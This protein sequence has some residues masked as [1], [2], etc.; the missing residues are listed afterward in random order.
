MGEFDLAEAD[1][2][3]ATELGP[4]RRGALRHAGQPRRDADP[5]GADT[6]PRP[7]TSGPRSRSKPDQFQAY[8]NLAQAYQ[9][10]ERF[11][12][13]LER[14]TGRSPG[15][16]GRRSCT[17]RAPRSTG[18]GRTTPKALDDLGRAIALSPPDDPA[19]AG[20]H[21]ER[22]LIFQQA[23]RHDEALAECD[24]ALALQPD[25]PDVH[26]VRGAVLVRLKRFDEAIRS[27]DVC[28]ARGTPSASLYE[29]R[30]LALA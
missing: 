20:D 23:G 25:R 29:A 18:S 27:F 10:L 24:R 19:L 22:A 17:G 11:D 14:S 9:N 30:G 26:R 3:R 15:L 1:F 4:R 6:R 8:V 28:L 7:R 5:P 13:A 16:P 21:L 12:D 2:E